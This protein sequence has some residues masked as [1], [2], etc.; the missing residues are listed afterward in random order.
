MNRENRNHPEILLLCLYTNIQ[1]QKKAL[2]S[3]SGE[4]RNEGSIL[5]GKG[6]P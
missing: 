4:G 5:S 2:A 1:R 6:R 3:I